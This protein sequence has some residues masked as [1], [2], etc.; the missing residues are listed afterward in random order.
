MKELIR[1]LADAAADMAS[2]ELAWWR[3]ELER[4]WREGRPETAARVGRWIG[5]GLALGAVAGGALAALR[6]SRPRR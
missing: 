5:I 4:P 3:R 6:V 1:P 2:A